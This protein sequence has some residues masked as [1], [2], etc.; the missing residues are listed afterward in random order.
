MTWI[1]LA[2]F[3]PRGYKISFTF[4]TSALL[5]RQALLLVA[6]TEA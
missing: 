4:T 5:H 6:K 1:T 3:T 2:E